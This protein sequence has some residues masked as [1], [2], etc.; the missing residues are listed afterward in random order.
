MSIRGMR[1]PRACAPG[2][3]RTGGTRSLRQGRDRRLPRLAGERSF[4]TRFGRRKG[5]LV[6]IQ[7]CEKDKPGGFTKGSPV[8]SPRG[9]PRSFCLSCSY[10][11]IPRSA[12]PIGGDRRW[13]GAPPLFA[14]RIGT[15]VLRHLHLR[16]TPWEGRSRPKYPCGKA[17]TKNT[18]GLLWPSKASVPPSGAT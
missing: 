5:G 4:V 7:E 13:T 6:P 3:R 2:Q 17:P 8:D 14:S 12:V 11:H 10:A 15:A 18:E 16:N 1:L 9:F